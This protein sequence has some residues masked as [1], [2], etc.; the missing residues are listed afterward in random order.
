MAG[1]VADAA[2]KYA[3]KMASFV[4]E[5]RLPGA[6]AGVVHGND[7]VWA[8]GTGFGDIA[9]RRPSESRGLYRI[10]SIT[11]TFTATAIMQL[12]DEGRLDLDDPVVVHVPEL[13][14]SRNPFGRIESVTLRRMLSHES[15]LQNNPPGV[16]W[17][18][19][20]YE[21]QPERNIAR[22]EQISTGVRPNAQT[23]YSNIAYQLLGEVVARIS[24]RPYPA[25]ICE[26]ILD[27]LGMG[28]T[29]FEPL[30]NDLAGRKATGYNARIFSDEFEIARPS[31]EAWAE[32]GL[33][34]CVEDIARWVSFQLQDGNKPVSDVLCATTR[35][36][37]Q[38]ARYLSDETWTSAQSRG[39]PRALLPRLSRFPSKSQ[40]HG[41][42]FL[43][44][45]AVK[46]S[47]P[48]CALSGATASLDSPTSS[49]QHRP[50]P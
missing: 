48:S 7:L 6:A 24:G 16:D 42:L 38:T 14:A 1:A 30:P 40:R 28:A 12:R 19:A 45:T 27:P 32:G 21:G 20:S 41:D 25:Y 36:E 47:V 22:A 5:N 18:T 44:S 34:S 49:S 29:A 50:S 43:A 10:A 2:S 46:H 39:G 35:R 23:K 9:G 33:W 13:K 15:G 31:P 3:A 8:A 37:M 11:K 4:K 26:R 17:S